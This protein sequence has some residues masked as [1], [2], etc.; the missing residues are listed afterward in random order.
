M[1]GLKGK[2]TFRPIM[3]RKA[4]GLVLHEN[5]K[6]KDDKSLVPICSRIGC[7]SRISSTK[8]ALIDHKA[9]STVSSFRSFSNGKES[10]GSSSRSMSGFGG[11]KKASKVGCRRQLSSLLDMDSSESSSVN[12][13]SPTSERVLP[14]GKTKESTMVN[15]SGEVVTEAGSSSRGTRRSIH[16]RP[17]LV[18]REARMG[19][20]EQNA[21]AS[22]N[23]NGLKD[24]RSK[25]GS[26]V[27]PSNSNPIRKSN[28]FRKKNS[29]GESSSSNRGNKTEGSVIGGR[30]L[31]SPQGNGIT[32][33]ES[34]RNRNI[35]NVRDNSV[36]SSSTRR[37]TGNYGRTGRAGAVATLQAPRPATLADLNPSRSAEVSRSPLNSYSRPI[38]SN[39]RLRS[40]MMPGSPSE[41]GLSHSLM[42][43]DG[44]RRYN[45]NGVA[46]VL[47]ALERIEQ[48]EELTYEQLAVLETNLFLNGMSSFHDQHRDMRLDI[49]NMSYEELL[50]LEEKMGTVSTALSEEA[51]LKSLKSSIYRPNDES[52]DICLNKDDDVKCSICQEEYVDGDEVG[53]LPCQHK[54]HV[55]CAQQWLRMKNWCPICK[56]SAE[57]QPQ[58][59]S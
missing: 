1:D 35:P 40:L 13:E 33:S 51:L 27:L 12:E 23:K 56:T 46:E 36:V 38:S 15:V 49:D 47:L 53:T 45:M 58:P 10:V 55:S 21:R 5:M 24:L 54:Y 59:F 16:Q 37:S 34:R 22:V 57:S 39:G 4:S 29:D 18:T 30:N 31:S 42:N 52:D 20:S 32:I 6:K 7:S 41:G 9:K 26:D 11:T 14:R 44:F 43:R 3:Q 19:N 50:A 25:S 28:I 8:G 48:D 2:R 17:D